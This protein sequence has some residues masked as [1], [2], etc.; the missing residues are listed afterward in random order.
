M[1][2]KFIEDIEDDDEEDNND[3]NDEDDDD[4]VLEERVNQIL[5]SI[6]EHHRAGYITESERDELLYI[7]NEGLYDTI[8]KAASNGKKMLNSDN[9]KGLS[10]DYKID[11]LSSGIQMMKQAKLKESEDKKKDS[12]LRKRLNFAAANAGVGK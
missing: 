11:G 4:E 10:P 12:E 2:D 3:E 9:L 7:V 8:L 1:Y 6:H 5:L